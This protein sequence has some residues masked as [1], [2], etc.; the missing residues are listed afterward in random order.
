MKELQRKQGMR[1]IL[2]S[3]PSLI[4]LAALTFFLAKG[5]FRFVEIER[6]SAARVRELEGEALALSYRESELTAEIER[7]KTQEGV[8]EEVKEKFSATREGEYVAII[9]D[10]KTKAT[11]TKPTRIERIK[12]WWNDLGTLWAAS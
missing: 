8:V 5:A 1:Q 2:Y 6:G 9:V 12:K 7:L 3:F 11:T 10:G 4:L